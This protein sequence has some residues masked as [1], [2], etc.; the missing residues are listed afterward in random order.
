MYYMPYCLAAQ[1]V[2]ATLILA[3]HVWN[4]SLQ[5]VQCIEKWAQVLLEKLIYVFI[6]ISKCIYIIMCRWSNC[7][8]INKMIYSVQYT[9]YWF[10]LQYKIIY[11]RKINVLK[12]FKG[13]WVVEVKF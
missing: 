1:N 13:K 10:D 11:R 3:V 8:C 12:M 7:N 4:L 2:Q 6:P 5:F 9:V